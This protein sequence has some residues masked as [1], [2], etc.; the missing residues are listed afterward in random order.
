MLERNRRGPFAGMWVFPGGQVDAEDTGGPAA[1]GETPELAAARKTAVREAAEE[2]GLALDAQRLVVH[3]WWLPPHDAPRRFATWFFLAPVPG[4][5]TVT[6]DGAEIV[7]HRWVPPLAALAARDREQLALATP[8]WM[9]LW[10]LTPYRRAADALAAAAARSPERFETRL[11]RG[12]GEVVAVWE[13]DAGYE[14]GDLA[15]TGPR[16]RLR[17]GRP[18][19]RVELSG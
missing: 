11:V 17:M 18:A 16:R 15:V 4:G 19:W 1:A 6:V 5:V 7:G 14:G 3:S 8:T 13:G 10:W 12:D 9:T 2:A